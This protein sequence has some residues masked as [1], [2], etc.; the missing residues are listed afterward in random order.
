M[1]DDMASGV[2]AIQQQLQ[3][4]G[5]VKQASSSTTGLLYL[6]K[7]ITNSLPAHNDAFVS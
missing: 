6:Q 4:K 1:E 3:R 2:E 5:K 7:E